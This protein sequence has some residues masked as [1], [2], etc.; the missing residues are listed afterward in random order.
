V[1]DASATSGEG[2]ATS[3]RTVL[4]SL[5]A[6]IGLTAFGSTADLAQSSDYWTVVA[7]PD[8]QGYA[9]DKTS[10]ARDQTRWIV[11]NRDAENIVFVSHEGDVVEHGDEDA[12]WEHMDDAMSLLDGTVPYST[13]TGNHD[14]ATVWDRNSPIEKYKKYFGPSRYDG[15]DW[16]GGAGPSNGEPNRDDL[17][18]YQLFSAGGY[19]FL[20]LAL[21]WEPPGSV[22][23]P[24]T[25][26]GWGQQVLD[27]YPDRPT[28]LTTHSY[29]RE[30]EERRTTTLQEE[31]GIG[32][33]GQ[34]VWEDLVGPNPQVFMV[35]CGHWG[36]DDDEGHQVST[37]VAGEPVY[38]LLANYQFRKN[39]GN[40]L[41]RRIEFRPG[42][43][44][45]GDDRIQGRTYSPSTD[46]FETDADSQFGF[47]LNFEERFD[48][49]PPGTER[50]TFRQGTD[51]YGG[52]VDTGLREADP[53][54]SYGD[55]ETATIDDDEPQD[56][57][58]ASQLLLRFD[59]I[60]GTGDGRI[61][62]GAN[63]Q[64]AIVTVETVEKGDGAAVHRMLA[65][66]TE[67]DTWASMDGGVQA[68]GTEAT[69]EAVARTGPVDEGPFT[70]DVS[71]SVQAWVSDPG[72]GN[73]GW[74]FRPLG[75]DGWDVATAESD[76]P[77]TL[78]VWYV[79]PETVLG[80]ADADGDVDS[81]DV[82]RVQRSIANEDVEIDREATD[83]DGDGDVDIG[84]A[85]LVRNMSED[86]S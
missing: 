42:D 50:V 8:T 11:D 58:N 70:L 19:D 27:Q 44:S 46:E 61:P 18:T 35:L 5:G 28:I 55:A 73:R 67:E 43:G 76:A 7:L 77:P 16:F 17:N 84:D 66:W 82:A 31:N 60:V 54:T 56:S 25:P 15:R 53:E 48:T 2:P 24:S 22:D 57:G 75:G 4:R 26:L 39:G 38:E 21:E 49:F 80:D 62:P 6:G 1:R 9:E 68:D 29:Y 51:G 13:V 12:E 41:L 10:Y 74:A 81:D 59:D 86:G 72:T 52:T 36:S 3:R 37:N 34:T 78:R 83:V 47:D 63:V 30:D 14:Y 45:D 32:N 69:S 64:S 71:G 79:P 85:V 20:H 65:D 23:D 33:T 40:G